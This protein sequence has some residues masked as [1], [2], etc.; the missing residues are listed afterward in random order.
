VVAV[1]HITISVRNVSNRFQLIKG[2]IVG[3]QKYFV[4]KNTLV[5]ETPFN[6]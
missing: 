1:I 3:A 6:L 4:P 2:T 5:E